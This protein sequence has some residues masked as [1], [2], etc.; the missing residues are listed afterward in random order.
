MTPGGRSVSVRG[1]R[2]PLAAI[3]LFA[4]VSPLHAQDPLPPSLR[5]AEKLNALVARVSEAQRGTT[6]L[7]ARFEQH[8]E[9]HLLA[10]P[11]VA[12][13]RFY[14]RAPDLVRWEYDVPRPMTV[15]VT[16]GTVVTYRPEERRAERVEVGR[17]QRRFL[18]FFSATQPLSDLREHFDFTLRDPGGDGRF[19]LELRPTTPQIKRRLRSIRLEIDRER[20]FPVVVAYDE[21]DGDLTRYLFSEV[22]VN[23]PVDREVFSLELPAD[24]EVVELRV[25]GD[26]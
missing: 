10:E 7:S 18:R 17:V 5:G 9:S 24:V 8:R 23:A 25:R 21:P 19:E 14:Y 3:A 1:M 2:G 15:L 22:I 12:H 6:T 4:A 20:F 11:A 16:G 26:E 13:G